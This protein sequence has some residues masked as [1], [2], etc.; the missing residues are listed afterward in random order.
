MEDRSRFKRFNKSNKRQG[1]VALHDRQRTKGSGDI[2][3][4]TVQHSDEI[5]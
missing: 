1:I 3:E 4:D 5:V 2:D